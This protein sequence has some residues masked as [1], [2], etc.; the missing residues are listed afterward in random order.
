MRLQFTDTDFYLE[1]QAADRRWGLASSLAIGVHVVVVLMALFMP[2]IF[3]SKPIVEEV[4]SVSLVSM[5]ETA[6]QS[7][8]AAAASSTSKPVA[9]KKA[10]APP[11]PPPPP[12]PPEPAAPPEP[13]APPPKPQV[14]VDSPAAPPE[15]VAA[16]NPVSI[17]PDKRKIKKA[18]DVRLEEDKVQEREAQERQAEERELKKKIEE[19]RHQ[20]QQRLQEEKELEK[21][22]EERRREA[23]QKDKSRR[24]AE[25]QKML[26][27]AKIDQIRA[28]NEAKQAAAE[29]R[30]LEAEARAA[31]D[32]V[33]SART[34]AARQT[35]AMQNALTQTSTGRQQAQSLVEKQYEAAVAS[36]VKSF[37]VL[38]EMRTWDSG[39]L[40]QVVITINKEGEVMSI[41]F[42]QR[43]KDPLFDQLVEK[44]IKSATP[45]PRFP[46]VM[47]Q[48][49]IEIGLKFRPGELGNM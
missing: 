9:E 46:A 39:L 38:P 1:Q 11:P 37:W 35:Q 45:M 22:I 47:Q 4:V 8:P 5:P 41:Q 32:A 2:T 48:E 26:A 3:V 16:T 14:S 28:E 19:R 34:E 40:A 49:T 21:K 10:E 31:R 13:V 24:E 15:P 33:G 23:E 20:A 17:F 29:A 12:P 18:Q 6:A 30:Q 25:R 44:T 7:A 27:Q 42:D 43:S 36:R